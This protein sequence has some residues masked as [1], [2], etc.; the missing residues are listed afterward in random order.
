[1]RIDGSVAV[2]TGAASGLGAATAAMLLSAGARVVSFDLRPHRLDAPE[3]RACSASGSITS[4]E[5]V[6]AAIE[7]ARTRFGRLDVLVN[8]AG[9][10]VSAPTLD[11]KGPT[12]LAGFAKAVEVNL[13]GTFNCIRLAAHA[14]SSNPPNADGERGVI[15]NTASA[16]AFEGQ[17]GQ[18]AYSASKAGIVG[19]TLPIARDLSAAG[20]RVVTV[21]PGL[22]ETPM[23][24]ALPPALRTQLLRQSLF[25]TRAGRPEEFAAMVAEVV[26]NVMV[27]GTTVRLDGGLRLPPR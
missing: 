8:C 13:V 15:V 18:A 22:F 25:P 9:I 23:L 27:N 3:D 17:A 11:W 5:E 16:A 2:V 26:R 12:P 1:M 14:M 6:G 24:S 4:E 20:I 10:G 21:A 19:M 7:V